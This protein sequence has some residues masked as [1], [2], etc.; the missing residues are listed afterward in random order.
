MKTNVK[1]KMGAALMVMSLGFGLVG[2]VNTAQAK[3]VVLKEIPSKFVTAESC[4]TKGGTGLGVSLQ[5]DG[6]LIGDPGG[7][8]DGY[9][10]SVAQTAKNKITVTQKFWY[11]DMGSTKETRKNKAK[12]KTE[13]TVLELKGKKLYVDGSYCKP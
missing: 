10:V 2:A 12:A 11:V 6:V 7:E 3:D 5:R 13:K 1:F 9:I 8:V 4:T